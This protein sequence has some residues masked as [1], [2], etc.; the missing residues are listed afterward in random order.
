MRSARL[1][2]PALLLMILPTGLLAQAGV[3]PFLTSPFALE[4]GD[5][6]LGGY[7]SIEEEVELFGVWRY[8]VERRLD[9][10]A[11]V[12]FTDAFDG[13]LHIGGDLRYAFPNNNPDD[14]PVNFALVGGIQGSFAGNGTVFA[15][16]FG[17]SVGADVGPPDRM[18][19]VYG[20]PRLI[21][22]HINPDGPGSNTEF[23]FGI[24]LGTEVLIS[25][26]LWGEANLTIVSNDGDNVALAFGLSYSR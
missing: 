15:F 19:L 21:I 14:M 22:E 24:E 6:K 3:T 25:G 16:P 11:R 13:G 8:G 2:I 9:L 4:P 20:L 26:S 17:V 12:G 10:G 7:F 23:E 5:S 1:L 18:V